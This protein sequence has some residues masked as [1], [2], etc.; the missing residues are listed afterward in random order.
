MILVDDRDGSK[1]LAAPLRRQGLPVE[2]VRL[3]FGDIAFEGRGVGGA[4]VQIGIEFKQLRELVQALRTQRLQGHQVPGMRPLFDHS[5]LMI[6]GELIYDSSGTLLRRSALSRLVPLEGQMTVNELL[7][8]VNVLHI[9]GGM[10]PY[11]TTSRADSIQTLIALYQTWT[12]TDMDQ[13]KSHLG[14][15]TA[16]SILPISDQRKT[17]STFP[18]IGRLTSK[19]VLDYF[20]SLEKAVAASA[21]Q[22]AEVCTADPRGRKR[23]IGLKHAEDIVAFIQKEFT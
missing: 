13:H 16:T 22:W 2:L 10:N 23:R 15:Y 8:R 6:E 5:Y 1:D 18:H 12:D 17:L 11:W 21:P 7:K 14:I 9:C 20:G 3:D 19:A 4:P